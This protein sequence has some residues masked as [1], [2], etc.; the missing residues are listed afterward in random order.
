M[1][2]AGGQSVLIAK[3]A[4][5]CLDRQ[6]ASGARAQQAQAA[7]Q[8]E[9][10][11]VVPVIASVGMRANSIGKVFRAPAHRGKA[12]RSGILPGGKHRFR[13]FGHQR[14]YGRCANRE[15]MCGFE[16]FEIPVQRCNVRRASRFRKHDTAGRGRHHGSEIGQCLI[17]V[18]RVDPHPQPR[19]I[20]DRVPLK[21]RRN[22]PSRFRLAVGRNRIFQVEQYDIRIARGGLLHL[23]VAI[24][25]REQ[26]G[27]GRAVEGR[28]HTHCPRH[29]AN[30]QAQSAP[31]SGI[32]RW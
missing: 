11:Q 16:C 22:L 5:D 31:P 32:R 6:N 10:R 8:F 20:I 23:A 18:Q 9:R 29:I 13:H 26:P 4:I 12:R 27:T 17:A 3:I 28:S 21:H 19:A 2:G 1:R 14:N 30:L 7:R 15:I 24:A 25:R